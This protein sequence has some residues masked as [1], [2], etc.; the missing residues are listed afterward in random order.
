MTT[1]AQNFIA[2]AQEHG[3]LQFGEFKTK[4]GRM[5]PYFFNTGLFSRGSSL[6]KLAAFYSEA[7]YAQPLA[8]DVIFGSAYKGIPLACAIALQFAAQNRDVAFCFNRKE[9]K[10]HGEGGAIIG[11]PLS[12]NVLIVDDVL[13]AGT[14][15]RESMALIRAHQATA[16]GVIVALDR[17]EQAD[18]GVGARQSIVE[19]Y[20]LPVIAIASL[21]D[22]MDFLAKHDLVH[23]QALRAYQTRYGCCP[24]GTK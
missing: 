21:K 5:S 15:I 2:F 17:M 16:V 8:F 20:G 9:L 11:A 7:L 22:I 14:S 24:G 12:G 18:H 4:A 3:I 10:D 23:W 19:D 6:A 1:L 13:S